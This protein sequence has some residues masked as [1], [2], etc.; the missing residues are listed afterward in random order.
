MKLTDEETLR[1]RLHAEA[2][3]AEVGPAPVEAVFRRYRAAR[4]HVAKVHR[5]E[6]LHRA[7]VPRGVVGIERQGAIDQWIA[8]GIGPNQLEQRGICGI[9]ID[10]VDIEVAAEKVVEQRCRVSDGA[11]EEL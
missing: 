11:R 3:R 6:G 5:T 4:W 1:R 8:R 10:Q 7:P 2:D 9:G